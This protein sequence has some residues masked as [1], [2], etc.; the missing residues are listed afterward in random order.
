MKFRIKDEYSMTIIITTND[1]L[2]VRFWTDNDKV[3]FD[4]NLR[5]WDIMSEPFLGKCWGFA[6]TNNLLDEQQFLP[7]N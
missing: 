4:M 5:D 2:R 6:N 7:L 3:S 1:V